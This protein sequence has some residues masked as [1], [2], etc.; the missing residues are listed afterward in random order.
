MTAETTP[1]S[2]FL[3][4]LQSLGDALSAGSLTDARTAF[5]SAATD[6]PDTAAE[7]VNWAQSEVTNDGWIEVYGI[8]HPG[9]NTID[10][11]TLASEIG[12]LDASLR[13]EQATLAGELTALGYSQTDANTYA[14]ALTG[15]ENG[16]AAD[17]ATVDATRAAQWI[18]G[19]IQT[20][21]AGAA[22]VKAGE[23]LPA[24]A[25]EALTSLLAGVEFGGLN[26]IDRWKQIQSLIG[27]TMSASS[28][29]DQA[30]S[31]ATA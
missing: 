14:I 2:A 31:P 24:S 25:A 21:E 23:Q 6:R 7:A 20:G 5:A 27:A 15:I 29:S 9:A 17:N 16:S 8:E 26:S 13:E 12:D 1:S 19:L 28:S 18:Q 10:L 11:G 30:A 22:A 3:S 4:N